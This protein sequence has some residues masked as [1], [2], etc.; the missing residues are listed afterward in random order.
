MA[1]RENLPADGWFYL[2]DDLQQAVEPRIVVLGIGRFLFVEQQGCR[3][4]LYAFVLDY[5]HAAV[6]HALHEIPFFAFRQQANWDFEEVAEHL[7]HHILA[8]IGIVEKASR[9]AKHFPVI[10]PEQLF[11]VRTFL[12][13]ILFVQF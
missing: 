8:F 4:F 5:V 13:H 11:Y 1:H 10:T 6:A 12:F 7:A 3:S 2:L 9:K